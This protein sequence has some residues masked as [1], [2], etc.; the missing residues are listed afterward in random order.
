MY[1][2]L[3]N[4]PRWVN[5]PENPTFQMKVVQ[6]L[7]TGLFAD[8]AAAGAARLELTERYNEGG[9]WWVANRNNPE[10]LNVARSFIE[11]SLL[12]VAIEYRV[13]AQESGEPADYA[14]AAE[15]YKEYLDKF[16]ISDDYYEQQWYLA[17]SYKRANMPEDAEREY[18][19]LIKSQKY[20]PYGDGSIYGLFETRYQVAAELGGFDKRPEDVPVERTYTKFEPKE[21]TVY[22]LHP[23]HAGM[24][25]AVDQVMAHDFAPPESDNVP[26]YAA[27]VDKRRHKLMY[28]AGQT[29]FN[30]NRYEEMRP[31]LWKVIE[32]YPRE[33]EASYAASLIVDSY[34]NEDDLDNTRKVLTKFATMILGPQDAADPDGKF[35][36]ALEQTVFEQA[37]RLGK[38]GANGDAAEAFLGFIDQFPDS[39]NKE[40]ALYN[41][42]FYFGEGG[43]AQRS[44]ELYEQFVNEFPNSERSKGL[45]FRIAANYEKIFELDKAIRYY[46]NLARIFPDSSDAADALYNAAFLRVGI[47]DYEGAA[48]GYEKYATKYDKEDAERVFFRAGEQWEQVGDRQGMAFY[49]RYEDRYGLDNPDHALKGMIRVAKIHEKNNNKRAYEKQ[50]D[51]IGSTFDTLV[52]RDAEIGPE[53]RHAA[54]EAG[55]REVEARF[56]E[57][58]A[59]KLPKDEK[60]VAELLNQTKPPQLQ[61][62]RTYTDD[63]VA[64]YLDFDYTM[65]AYL[66]QA[67]A[68]FYYADLG[69]SVKPPSNLSE[70]EQWAYFDVLEEKF[71]PQFYQVEDRAVEHLEKNVIGLAVEQKRHSSYVDDAYALLNKRRPADFADQKPEKKGE[72]AAHAV[73]RVVPVRMEPPPEPEEGEEDEAGGEVGPA[74]TP[75]ESPAPSPTPEEAPQ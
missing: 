23:A 56:A 26:D 34:V 73:A 44:N 75:E 63:Y 39:E 21:I 48:R 53:G 47:G 43:K 2:H 71:F 20:H 1:R 61:E 68:L 22:E 66:L 18:A 29:L 40:T 45:Y 49:K 31:R 12:D 5:R 70:E 52:A 50:L 8:P 25:E 74:P 10:A 35:K 42:A 57:L 41:A 13:R 7:G 27:E 54:A 58:T 36:N 38:A 6:L 11:G 64:K 14:L 3:Q 51:K 46:E 67:K 72:V 32:E 60:K 17:D 4:D 19:S 30:Y 24:I 33:L 55:F 9:E 37:L 69:L 59:D 62:F 15:K 65:A 28:I 16:P